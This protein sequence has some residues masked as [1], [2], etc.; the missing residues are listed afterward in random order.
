ML[1]TTVVVYINNDSLILQQHIVAC[2]VVNAF[3]VRKTL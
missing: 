2:F 3:I 1:V